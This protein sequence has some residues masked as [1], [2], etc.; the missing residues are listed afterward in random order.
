MPI[1]IFCVHFYTS[2]RLN[3]SCKLSGNRCISSVGLDCDL[4]KQP[5]VPTT[6]FISPPK[7]NKEKQ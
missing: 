2:Q 1:N 3:S 4:A 7:N 6:K 5:T